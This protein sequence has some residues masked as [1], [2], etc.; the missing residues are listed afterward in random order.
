MSYK[1]IGEALKAI[2]ESNNFFDSTDNPNAIGRI[3]HQQT[4]DDVRY[5]GFRANMTPKMFLAATD[6]SDREMDLSKIEELEADGNTF[7]NPWLKMEYDFKSRKWYVIGH[8]GRHR[9]KYYLEKYG[10][11]VIDIDV[12]TDSSKG[13]LRNRNL[14]PEM[15]NDIGLYSQFKSRYID[16]IDELVD[17]NYLPFKD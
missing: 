4:D 13:E 12:S 7:A 15:F 5:F 3:S 6:S 17:T 2:R 14:K 16:N 11:D 10:N 9:A 8:E 1:I